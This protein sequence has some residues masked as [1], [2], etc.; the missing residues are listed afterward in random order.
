MAT[1]S[2]PMVYRLRRLPS[3]IDNDFAASQLLSHAVH[4]PSAEI[5][6]CSLATVAASS[7][8]A[9]TKVATV[10]FHNLPQLIQDAPRKTEWKISVHGL[11]DSLILDSHFFGM[12]P[13]YDIMP[14]H[15]HQYNCIA[16]SGLASHPFGS[17]Q[18]KGE[19]KT[20]MWLRDALP[21]EHPTVRAWIY[22]YDTSLTDK[23]SFQSIPDLATALI[24]HMKANDFAS[25][26]APKMIIIAH[27]L[28]GIVLKQAITRLAICGERE[29][30]ALDLIRGT[31]FFGVPNLGME[32]SHL[33]A[34]VEN[35][36]NQAIVDDLAVNSK[37]LLKL[38]EQFMGLLFNQK[39]KRTET[40]AIV[41][42]ETHAILVSPESATSNL[43]NDDEAPIS[44]F[45]INE[46]HSNMVKFVDDDGVCKI[47]L[48]KIGEIM[49]YKAPLPSITRAQSWTSNS[50]TSDTPA[51]TQDARP[52][53]YGYTPLR[54]HLPPP[55]DFQQRQKPR[56]NLAPV[57]QIVS[58]LDV[59]ELHRRFE[60]IEAR[61]KHTFEWIY[62]NDELEFS[63]WLRS[64][65]GIYWI[66]GKPGSG[67]ST[68]M[69][70]I[71]DD[72]R[73]RDLLKHWRDENDPIIAG[74]FFH[75]RGSVLQKS[76]E[77]L[78]RSILAQLLRQRP[79]LANLLTPLIESSVGKKFPMELDEF[80]ALFKSH[81]WTQQ[82][83]GHALRLMLRQKIADLDM[84]FFFDALDE[85]DGS[86]EVIRDFLAD[87]LEE[88][89]EGQTTIKICFSSRPWESFTQK[90][91]SGPGFPIHD[92]TTSDIKQYC[93]Q[94]INKD[95]TVAEMLKD[96]VPD[97]I[98]TAQGVF[99][100][101]RLALSD[102][103][104]AAVS[105][106][107]KDM[108]ALRQRLRKLPRDLH[109]YY[110]DIVKRCP[111]ALKE[112]AYALLEIVTRSF[113]ILPIHQVLL[114]LVC[115]YFPTYDNCYQA[116]NTDK[117]K[118]F[119][120]YTARRLINSAC[121][122]LLEITESKRQFRIQLMHQTV[123]EFVLSPKF[124][125]L[126]LG[127]LAKYQH[128]NGHSFF[129]KF[130]F[131]F[132]RMPSNNVFKASKYHDDVPKYTD[133]D[134]TKHCKGAELT[135]GK[136]QI[137]FLESVPSSWLLA[138]T[139]TEKPGT[140]NG[141][142]DS[143]PL[144]S[145][146]HHDL[147]FIFAVQ[148]GL[149]LCIIDLVQRYYQASEEK[150]RLIYNFIRAINGSQLGSDDLRTSLDILQASDFRLQGM[151]KQLFIEH[152][153]CFCS[154]EVTVSVPD[155]PDFNLVDLR[156]DM[157]ELWI[158]LLTQEENPISTI[159]TLVDA[160][161]VMTHVCSPQLVLWLLEHGMNPSEPDMDGRTLVDYLV[162]FA[163]FTGYHAH[164]T[165]VCTQLIESSV[166]TLQQ[167]GLPHQASRKVWKRV[168]ARLAASKTPILCIDPE[169]RG[170][171][172][173]S[174]LVQ[175]SDATMMS[176]LDRAYD[177][178]DMASEL[179]WVPPIAAARTG[180]RLMVK[181][182][183]LLKIRSK[184]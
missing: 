169:T 102:L 24:D 50:S 66:S 114:V 52:Q 18:P 76:L 51:P 61:S 37:Y 177:S 176:Y 155:A 73:T 74:F 96:L 25:P 13:L 119:N 128:E 94:T 9:S 113:E 47:I 56:L 49:V 111:K 107:G 32:Q 62:E 20:F 161:G 33:H 134:V 165:A 5:K 16:I 152:Q 6:I 175:V 85:Y 69:K 100:W 170:D 172:Q 123:R 2:K 149:H 182:K 138:R 36:P 71:F 14:P 110:E 55:I 137:D 3:Y 127:D 79:G 120:L 144:S 158:G 178:L 140:S 115:S 87:L 180:R 60:D 75:H 184:R 159:R 59:P 171:A 63:S 108:T 81:T 77:G 35:Q 89:K 11:P 181:L 98:E 78:I 80:R 8:S 162:F 28:G 183:R 103:F 106:E 29:L 45:P 68:L 1:L 133:E 91:Q 17:W 88:S 54:L 46:D 10:M 21:R 101:A 43:I 174:S 26:T 148:N 130:M 12:T 23:T 105:S 41:R 132:R 141:N 146:P 57:D 121:G 122:G 131:V 64:G 129:F 179:Q 40:G 70:F 97:I 82:H 126:I 147:V 118:G 31:V 125:S 4:L 109:K 95:S 157:L 136:S 42:S 117:I 150:D 39:M 58:S 83:L 99:L 72:P 92:Y 93:Y 104:D 38:N 143:R 86:P 22:G 142:H 154:A 153:E 166:M 112:K 124:K 160:C 53:R 65:K 34:L 167:G 164:Q 145:M 48:D 151:S 27:S 67:K 139:K 163:A 84:C 19:E 135:T 30:H 15:E 116:V 44:T 156:E 173:P 7:W 90:F 168:R